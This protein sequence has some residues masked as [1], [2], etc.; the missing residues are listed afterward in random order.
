M[1][2]EYKVFDKG[3]WY[4]NP[5]SLEK[6]LNQYGEEGWKLVYADKKCFIFMREKE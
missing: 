1:E 5:V 4:K 2:Y 3:P 6:E